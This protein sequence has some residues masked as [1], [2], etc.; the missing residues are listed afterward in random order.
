MKVLQTVPFYTAH[1]FTLCRLPELDSV[2][3]LGSGQFK[4]ALMFDDVM[5]MAKDEHHK[6]VKDLSKVLQFDDP[7]NIQFTSVSKGPFFKH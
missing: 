1:D 6:E 5:D 3:M 7:I 2:I 4:G